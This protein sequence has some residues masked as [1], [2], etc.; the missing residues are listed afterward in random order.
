MDFD[1][2]WQETA[3][4]AGWVPLAEVLDALRDHDGFV[5][6]QR[7]GPLNEYVMR[8][9]RDACARYLAERFAPTAPRSEP[10]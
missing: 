1:E 5:Q 2:A 9:D 10:S 4:A 3:G 7:Q 6:W 8:K